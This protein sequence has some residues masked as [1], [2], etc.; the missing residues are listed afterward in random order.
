MATMPLISGTPDLQAASLTIARITEAWPLSSRCLFL[1]SARYAIFHALRA[2]RIRAGETVLVPAYCCGTEID[3]LLLAGVKIQWCDVETSLEIAS[4]IIEVLQY[5]KCRAVLLTHYF[6][7]DRLSDELIRY[8]RKRDILII[9]DCSHAFLSRSTQGQPLGSAGDAAVF[10]LRKSLGIPDG[11]VL[12]TNRDYSRSMLAADS[13][14]RPN[15]M[16]VWYRALQL[17]RKSTSLNIPRGRRKRVLRWLA[18]AALQ[19]RLPLRVLQKVSGAGADCLLDPN[20]YEFLPKA[21]WWGMSDFSKRRLHCN[22]QEVLERRRENYLL[23]LQLVADIPEVKPLLP[24]LPAGACPLLFP[25]VVA[26]R[27]A[28]W[29]QLLRKGIDSHPWWGYF[30]PAV[31]WDRFPVA[32]KLKSEVLGLPVHQGLSSMH[33][34][35]LSLALREALPPGQ[36]G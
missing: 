28:V 15:R 17:V 10:S 31:S 23:L 25:L 14:R 11:A 6:G 27:L 12:V 30:H 3:P 5:Q 22:Y 1:F 35:R 20:S 8:C 2:L 9:E 29:K 33:M 21:L 18:W 36:G 24:V 26:N 13:F 19:S 16:A 32:K 7:I 34:E 4:R